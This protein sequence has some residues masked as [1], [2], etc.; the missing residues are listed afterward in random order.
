[1]ENKGNTLLILLIPSIGSIRF[2]STRHVS[3]DDS[4]K[5][6]AKMNFAIKTQRQWYGAFYEPGIHMAQVKWAQRPSVVG[7]IAPPKTI[8]ACKINVSKMSRNCK[9]NIQIKIPITGQRQHL[10]GNFGAPGRHRLQSQ[11]TPSKGSS[12]P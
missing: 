11:S 12:S 8:T 4:D 10:G 1:M 7:L 3:E 2:T 5:L 6:K 9:V